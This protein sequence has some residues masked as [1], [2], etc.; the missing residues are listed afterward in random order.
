M[1]D[2]VWHAPLTPLRFLERAV[3]VHPDAVSIVDG[4]DRWTYREFGARAT[5]LARALQAAGVGPGDRVAFCAPNTPDLLVAHFAV[6]LA[7]AVLVAVNTRLAPAEVAYICSHSGARLLFVH[8]TLAGVAPAGLPAIE[9][10]TAAYEE[11]LAGGSQAP[12]PWSVPD[13]DA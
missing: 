7:G 5:R 12:L 8:P 10:E 2:R 1:G 3:E 4:P 13:E 6:P 9:L 11:F